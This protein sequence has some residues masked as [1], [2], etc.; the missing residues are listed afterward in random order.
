MDGRRG[1]CP[2]CPVRPAGALG[3]LVDAGASR[4]ALRCVFVPARHPLPPRWFGTYALALVRRGI[5]VRQRLDAAGAATAV[6][7]I[8]PGGAAPLAD[9]EEA[10][11][12]GYAVDDA[13]VCLVPRTA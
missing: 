12:G 11:S 10:T 4:C 1:V 2:D 8:G 5:I 13:L 6:D 3:P 9:S 7:V